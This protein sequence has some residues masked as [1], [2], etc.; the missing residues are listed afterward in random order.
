[1]KQGILT[2]IWY[3][4]ESASLTDSLGRAKGQGFQYV[5]LQGIFHVRPEHL[6]RKERQAV[7]DRMKVLEHVQKIAHDLELT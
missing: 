5:D 2:G 1:M 7:R 4:A 6:D 3:I